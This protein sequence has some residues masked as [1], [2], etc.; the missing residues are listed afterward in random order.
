MSD[1]QK[2]IATI[3]GAY[4]EI[5]GIVDAVNKS[6]SN[7]VKAVVGSKPDLADPC[8]P[9]TSSQDMTGSTNNTAAKPPPPQTAEF[10]RITRSLVD[11]L[12]ST[13]LFIASDMNALGIELDFLETHRTTLFIKNDDGLYM[14]Y[15]NFFE[16][17]ADY[18]EPKSS[19]HATHI[20]TLVNEMRDIIRTSTVTNIGYFGK[21]MLDEVKKLDG[22]IR[23]LVPEIIRINE[24]KRAINIGNKITEATTIEGIDNIVSQFTSP[25]A[26]LNE[27]VQ[28]VASTHKMKLQELASSSASANPNSKSTGT[29]ATTEIKNNV[30]LN[31]LTLSPQQEPIDTMNAEASIDTMNAEASIDPIKS[32]VD[33]TTA[34]NEQELLQLRTFLIKYLSLIK[35]PK[36]PNDSYKKVLDK[37]KNS[38]HDIPA[39]TNIDNYTTVV[40]NNIGKFTKPSGS[41]Q[42]NDNIIKYFQSQ[43]TVGGRRRTRRHRKSKRRQT[44]RA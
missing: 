24:E 9:K 11:Y 39:A 25:L 29:D 18:I 14:G 42:S 1:P 2:H 33:K 17:V 3:M 4:K 27:Q 31:A 38:I 22:A 16:K 12:K 34:L 44:K 30:A 23:A 15:A 28:G 13:N 8:A 40:K 37:Y 21:N 10:Q 26:H 41:V 5:R 20:R 35:N 32:I 7:D 36:K 43:P 19:V 6:H